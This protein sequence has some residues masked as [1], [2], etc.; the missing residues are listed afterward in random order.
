MRNKSTGGIII[1]LVF[2]LASALFQMV[3]LSAKAE[4]F[5]QR[6]SVASDGSQGNGESGGLATSADGRY[7]A[8]G[9]W[10]SNLV[11]G[12]TNGHM[13]DFV[14][15]RVTGATE[16]VSVASDGSEGNGD[17]SDIA[18]SADG[19]YVSFVSLASNLVLGDTNGRYDIFIHDRVTGA[20][21]RVS[22][23][24]DG[25]EGNGDSISSA[26][27][28][29]GRYVSF[30]SW[31]SNLVPGDTD[32]YYDVFVRDRVN[33]TTER[34]SV[35]SDGSQANNDS[36][37]LSMSPDGRYTTFYSPASNLVS[38]DTNN[39]WDIFVHDRVT[40]IT[41]RVSVASDGSQANSGSF[42]PYISPDSR[43]VTFK[44][45]ASNLIS[46]DTN[47]QGDI[48]VHDRV[49]GTTERVSVASDGSQGNNDCYYPSISASGRYVSFTS[50]A[51]NLVPDDTN[52]GGDIFVYDREIREVKRASI[53]INGDQG[54]SFSSSSLIS[55]DSQFVT[56]YSMAPNL[57]PNDTNGVL[58][59]FVTKNPFLNTV[60]TANPGP[61]QT[62]YIGTTAILDG[63]G[64]TDPSGD[65]P[66]IYSW[67]FTSVPNG[68]SAIINNP[69]SMNPTFLADI[70][71]DYIVSLMVTDSKGET[72]EP[73][74]VK[75]SA[76]NIPPVAETFPALA[77][78]ASS[79]SQGDSN[80]G[81]GDSPLSSSND[82]R[83]IAF[84]S[85]ASNLVPGDTNGMS[86]IFVHDRQTSRTSRV[87]VSSYGV[88]GNGN[89]IWPT[90]SADGR[91]VAFS[92]DAS[93]LVTGGINRKFNIFVHDRV[94]RTTE[95]VS[96]ASDGTQGNSD[97]YRPAIS[98]DG[99]YVVF[100]SASS[101]FVPGDT[102]GTWDIF[103][104]DRVAGTT[105]R[106]SIASDGSQSDNIS[107]VPT[108]S[109]DSR[110]VAFQSEASTLT[111]GDTN[112]RGDV[113][114]HDRE[115]HKTSMVSISS[116]GTQGNN[117]SYAPTISAD[118]RYVAFSSS[119]S[120]LVSGDTNEWMSDIFVHDR[121]TGETSRVS[122]SS[123]G[124]QENG[125]SRQPTISAD[126]RYIAFQSVASNLVPADTNGMQDV[127][128]HDRQ[129]RQMTIISVSSN[130]IQGNGH[131]GFPFISANGRYI[132]FSSSASN[133]VS[134]DANGMMDVFVTQNSLFNQL[135]IA[136]AGSNQTVH[137]GTIA[138]LD[139][140]QSTDPDRDYPLSYSWS[141][142]SKPSDSNVVINNPDS[143]NPTFL[144]DK[145]GNYA[146]S[147]VVTDSKGLTSLPVEVQ[148]STTNTAPVADAGIDQLVTS[149]NS[150]V[151]LDGGN[152]YDVD[153]DT[154]NYHWSIVSKPSG[155]NVEL[156]N[157]A[158]EKP[159]F[160]ADIC[161]DYVFSLTVS[162]NW[163]TS[164]ADQVTVG[165]DNIQ[166][167][168]N[169]GVNQAV[170]EGDTVNLNGNGSTDANG[171][172][173]T[174]R[175][176][177]AS[178]PQGSQATLSS[179][180][181]VQ[182][183]FTAD[184]AGPYV[185]NLIVNDG[186]IDSEPSTVN[187]TAIT[188]QNAATQELMTTVTTINNIPLD[189]FNNPNNVNALT[190]K[191]NAA[192]GNIS[193]GNYADALNQIQNDIL[194]K[195]DGCAVSGAPDNNDWITTESK[196]PTPEEI[197]QA[198]QKQSPV[199]TLLMQAIGYLESLI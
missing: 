123:S 35:A 25:S 99:R 116:D 83:Y 186:F 179:T 113:F 81:M 68:S 140:S 150:Q 108:I 166:P 39:T 28:A 17:S 87:S 102:N 53:S 12:D 40:G 77:S 41:E 144:A 124:V 96:V 98:A 106:V 7:T 148:I 65:Y 88:Q 37:W 158:A 73:A 121:Q 145:S 107:N 103:V 59:V 172:N 138:T 197:Q 175:W 177:L 174:Y 171:D 159:T 196:N 192:L 49:T 120:N 162:D 66:L 82:G 70:S 114:V 31:S 6:V 24:S 11:P 67:S 95:R 154:I 97:S 36:T 58:D 137:A 182:T 100:Q 111:P 13:D 10:S 2:V 115:T 3:P 86:D 170:V 147:L 142:T 156:S 47:E 5:P 130:G 168:A 199:Y 169:A 32:G 30:R 56:F 60:P 104:H 51:S 14:H 76:T 110:Y 127:F 80:S 89:S 61:N 146:V 18:I 69:D 16:R 46:D 42:Y 132:A 193:S 198:C 9:S 176:N 188:V 167:V 112:G 149:N 128:V 57:I 155:S 139:G 181:N 184:Q 92:S 136:N 64:S 131:S 143:V 194:G 84:V 19:R 153:G 161:S 157:S 29:D 135:P 50:Y 105:E 85:N 163:S 119:A 38:N 134:D 129:N 79:G 55:S 34:V 45:Y 90:I 191:I 118:G 93:T 75:I 26:V 4:I 178:V 43:Y 72:S 27:S 22:V 91:Y 173:L 21:E 101:T 15:D 141:F 117:Y 125:E 54:N 160:N 185:I 189:S 48:F 23:A 122:V 52:G 152:S 94:T 190:N 187:V 63:S 195:T 78:V 180:D 20:T 71:G 44:S 133:L 109:A 164:I 126:G 183:S 62:V 1:S 33:R 8:F 165:F 151:T 74:Q